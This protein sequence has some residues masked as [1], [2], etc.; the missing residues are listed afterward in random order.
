MV[1]VVVGGGVFINSSQPKL[2]INNI[3]PLAPKIHA[4]YS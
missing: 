1:V 3:F 4:A 2:H